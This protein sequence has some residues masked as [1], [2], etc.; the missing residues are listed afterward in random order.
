MASTISYYSLPYLYL[1]G[2]E[3]LVKAPLRETESVAVICSI[4]RLADY[5]VVI[6][7]LLHPVVKYSNYA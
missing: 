2:R 3:L 4:C 7:D 6:V 1:S 5:V